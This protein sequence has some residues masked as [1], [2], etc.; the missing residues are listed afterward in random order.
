M[1]MKSAALAFGALGLAA[2]GTARPAPAPQAGAKAPATKAAP[3]QA[4]RARPPRASFTPGPAVTATFGGRL[5]SGSF[6]G[7]IN[8]ATNQLCYMIEA[9]AV[10]NPTAAHI[11]QGSPAKPGAP[12]L[13]LQVPV[14]GS[15]G[16]C[17][18]L[19]ANVTQGLVSNPGSYYVDIAN[20][21]FPKGVVRAKLHGL[22]T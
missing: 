15:A 6:S 13:T 11:D 1:I 3:Q 5:A 12:V 9:P 14:N 8:P 17:Q 22:L 10:R 18:T 20:S 2:A 19:P 16:A 7:V 21:R 4:R